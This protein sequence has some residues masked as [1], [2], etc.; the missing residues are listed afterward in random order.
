[1]SSNYVRRTKPGLN[2]STYEGAFRSSFCFH[3][4]KRK[5]QYY[6]TLWLESRH[7]LLAF[8]PDFAV[9]EKRNVCT[10]VCTM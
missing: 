9:Y 3:A 6:S 4:L 8:A 2:S 7:F 10:S 5:Q 1:M